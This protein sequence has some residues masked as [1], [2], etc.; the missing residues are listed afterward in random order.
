MSS[1]PVSAARTWSSSPATW[2][3]LR[4]GEAHYPVRIGHE[5]CSVGVGAGDEATG[6]WMG[7]RVTGDTMLGAV[8][9]RPIV[10]A[11]IGLE[12]VASALAGHR[13]PEWGGC[14]QG[15]HRPATALIAG[16]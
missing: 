6:S 1:G 2:P 11:T 13:P 10:A 7:R 5:W 16:A 9:P 12:Q 4:T 15:A 3:I 14:P 8:D